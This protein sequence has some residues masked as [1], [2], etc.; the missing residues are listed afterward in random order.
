M[1]NS[2]QR[3]VNNDTFSIND[4]DLQAQNVYLPLRIQVQEVLTRWEAQK[5]QTF[6]S[7]I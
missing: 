5:R 7:S 2:W 4:K 6:S 3:G 1:C